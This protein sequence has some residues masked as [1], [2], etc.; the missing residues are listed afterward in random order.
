MMSDVILFGPP[1]SSYVRTARMVC[2]EKGISHELQPVE[3]RSQAHET[4]HPWLKVPILRHGDLQLFETSAIARYL[5]ET[6]DGPDLLPAT[7]RARAVM[8]QWVSAINCYI[9]DSVVRNYALRYILPAL[10]GQAPD[11]AAIDAA[12]PAMQR[13]IA[14]LD[15]AYTGRTWLAGD[16]LSFV[17]LLVAPIVQTAGMFPEGREALSKAGHLTRAFESMTQRPSYRQVHD[18]VFG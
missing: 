12:L 2:A 16:R 8:E 3:L 14:R 18:G 11:R 9:Y 4:L 13:D 15:G 17:D 10:R 5:N 1:Q 7:A 6:F